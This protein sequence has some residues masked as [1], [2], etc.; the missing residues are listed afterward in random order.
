MIM[1]ASPN[2]YAFQNDHLLKNILSWQYVYLTLLSNPFFY[3]LGM[4]HSFFTELSII[5]I[6]L[7]RT[8]IWYQFCCK[9]LYY[10]S[11]ISHQTNY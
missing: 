10:I 5:Y 7:G 11:I 1:T 4:S 9:A 3:G 6:D 2:R 8:R